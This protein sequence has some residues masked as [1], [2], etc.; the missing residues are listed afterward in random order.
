MA[1]IH[2]KKS[3]KER[4]PWADL[5]KGVLGSLLHSAYR[6]NRDTFP[7][8]SLRDLLH[9][10][11]WPPAPRYEYLGDYPRESATGWSDNIQG[12][13]STG[14][15]WYF[16][17]AQRGIWR[18]PVTHDLVEPLDG[19]HFKHVPVPAPFSEAEKRHLG[20]PDYLDDFLFVP[21]EGWQPKQ[22][23]MFRASNLQFLGAAPV[24]EQSDAPWCAI[25]PRNRMI[26]SSHFDTDHLNVYKLSIL[27]NTSG[28][29]VGVELEFRYNFELK[30]TDGSRLFVQ[31]VQ[32]GA[33][34]P[35]GHLYL[36]SD[37]DEGGI[38]GF[39]ITTGRKIFH[40]SKSSLPAGFEMEGITIFDAD[41][42]QA[43]HIGGQIHV[44]WLRDQIT[45]DLVYFSHFRVPPEDRPEI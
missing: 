45:D 30:D 17:Q 1:A 29:I 2:L 4:F 25:N 11:R 6:N 16:V 5:S 18:I 43:P 27:A 9:S 3:I 40:R 36:I 44:V 13:A 20:D 34:S 28:A 23:L 39:D 26:Y 41:S 12:V 10:F 32:G 21:F 7:Y 31:R 14:S 42:V 24:S 22:I 37:V 15:A 35:S 19:Q 33:F 8:K 38:L